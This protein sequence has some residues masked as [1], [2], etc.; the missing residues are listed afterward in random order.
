M[1]DI[2]NYSFHRFHLLHKPTYNWDTTFFIASYWD[3]TLSSYF[4]WEGNPPKYLRHL[5]Q[6]SPALE[7]WPSCRCFSSCGSGFHSYVELPERS[8]EPESTTLTTLQW[9]L[10]GVKPGASW[11]ERS[12]WLLRRSDHWRVMIHCESKPPSFL[13]RFCLIRPWHWWVFMIFQSN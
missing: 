9:V 7:K 1:V 2:S 3:I 13:R 11:T 6:W 10:R 5:D 12:R 8:T 4:L